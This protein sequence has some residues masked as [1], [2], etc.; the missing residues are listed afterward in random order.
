MQVT[1]DT[2]FLTLKAMSQT[3]TFLPTIR[4]LSFLFLLFQDLPQALEKRDGADI[5]LEAKYS[6]HT[7]VW[8][9]QVQTRQ[10][11]ITEKKK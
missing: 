2:E 4:F 1:R 9:A 3:T 7:Q 5:S 10:S 11:P 8:P 6:S